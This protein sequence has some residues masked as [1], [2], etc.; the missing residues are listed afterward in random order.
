VDS[1][2]APVVEPLSAPLRSAEITDPWPEPVR[3]KLAPTG[4]DSGNPFAAAGQTYA[5][6]PPANDRHQ[7]GWLSNLLAAASR[8]DEP[9][10]VASPLR[11]Q[12]ALE[13]LTQGVAALI[14]NAA[15]AEMWDRWRRGDTAAVSRRLYTEAGQQAYDE[16][17]RRYRIDSQFREMATRFTQEFE[18]LLAKVGQN[19][20]DGVQ[21]RSYL[22]SNTGKVYTIL[23]HASGRLG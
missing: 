21:W 4:D 3:P 11:G 23:A 7:A 18:R 8:D 12:D 16:I 1:I 14:D 20:R 6:P 15:A 5:P 22:L 19:D 13:E 9:D 2:I 10:V 17:R